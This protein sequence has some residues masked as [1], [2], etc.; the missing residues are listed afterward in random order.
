MYFFIVFL[1]TIRYGTKLGAIAY[2]ELWIFRTKLKPFALLF[3]DIRFRNE[4]IIHYGAIKSWVKAY[5][6][7]KM[8]REIYRWKA[9]KLSKMHGKRREKIFMRLQTRVNIDT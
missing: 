9:F 4:I 2:Q 5:L 7:A 6:L 8:K 1:S 3:T